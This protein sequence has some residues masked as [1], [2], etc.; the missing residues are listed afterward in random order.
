MGEAFVRHLGSEKFEAHSAGTEPTTLN[1]LAAQVMNERGIPLDGQSSKG[2]DTYLGKL[3]VSHLVIVCEQSEDDC[4]KNWPGALS[5]EVWPI[6]D[7]A[8]SDGL[9]VF[10]RVRDE[11]E[12]HVRTWLNS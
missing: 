4:P 8:H 6:E 10:R 11:I 7:P 9:D 5:R 12:E 3:S 2:V 1:P